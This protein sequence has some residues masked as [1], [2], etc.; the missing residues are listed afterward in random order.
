MNPKEARNNIDKHMREDG[1]SQ[2]IDLNKSH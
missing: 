1:M 2:I